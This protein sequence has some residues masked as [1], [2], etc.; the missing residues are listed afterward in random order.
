MGA[1]TVLGLEG[2]VPGFEKAFDINRLQHC[3]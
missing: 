1:A 3:L 2:V